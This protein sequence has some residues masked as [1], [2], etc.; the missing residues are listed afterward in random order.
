MR[1]PVK[2]LRS[3]IWNVLLFIQALNHA[4]LLQKLKGLKMHFLVKKKMINAKIGNLFLLKMLQSFIMIF[5]NYIKTNIIHAGK[6]VGMQKSVPKISMTMIN[7]M[8]SPSI[9]ALKKDR[10]KNLSEKIR[11]SNSKDNKEI[12]IEIDI[13]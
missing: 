2:K 6:K 13:I 12:V 7:A 9:W 3:L 8:N 11:Q 1:Q 5:F 10:T 4:N